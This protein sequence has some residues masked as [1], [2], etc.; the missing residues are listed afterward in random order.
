MRRGAEQSRGTPTGTGASFDT[1]IGGAAYVA[2]LAQQLRPD[3]I[4][5]RTVL[6]SAP[7]PNVSDRSSHNMDRT[8]RLH[9]LD[10]E[11]CS[12]PTTNRCVQMLAHCRVPSGSLYRSLS[13][14]AVTEVAHAFDALPVCRRRSSMCSRNRWPMVSLFEYFRQVRN[15]IFTPAPPAGRRLDSARDLVGPRFAYSVRGSAGE[16]PVKKQP[17]GAAMTTNQAQR[18][19]RSPREQPANRGKHALTP[20]RAAEHPPSAGRDGEDPRHSVRGRTAGR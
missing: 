8:K 9:R 18:R 19:R 15:S 11:R 7:R 1:V 2:R 20:T 16:H 17:D 13:S 5:H 12:G 6:A 4:F 14:V 10:G 3:R